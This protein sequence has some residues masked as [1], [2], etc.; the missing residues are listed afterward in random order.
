MTSSA[1]SS[2]RSVGPT[3]PRAA[4]PPAPPSAGATTAGRPAT[5]RPS[6][7]TAP[8]RAAPSS[9]MTG[10]NRL[11]STRSKLPSTS[12]NGRSD[13]STRPPTPLATTAPAVATTADGSLS[14]ASTDPAPR[15]A[16]ATPS[17]P[18]PLPTSRTDEPARDDVLQ[19]LEAQ[20]G[21]LVTARTEGHAGIRDHHDRALRHGLFVGPVSGGTVGTNRRG[22]VVTQ[23]GRTTSRPTD[24]VRSSRGQAAEPALSGVMIRN[25][26]SR[27]PE[28]RAREV[29]H[30]QH[31]VLVATVRTAGRRHGSSIVDDVGFG[32]RRGPQAEQLVGRE[33][34]LVAP[35]PDLDHHAILR[36]Q[37]V[38]PVVDAGRATG[39]VVG[40]SIAVEV[41]SGWTDEGLVT[42]TC[43]KGRA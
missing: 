38:R 35:D 23:L 3:P 12:A 18:V 20:A 39:H 22:R 1:R 2:H 5:S 6:G 34:D 43:R 41:G 25:R 42:G 30:E 31:R 27:P 33:L 14:I 36:A 9:S 15:S 11:A 4:P 21:R 32:H 28:R 26:R 24:H 16:A 29:G 37:S 17:T 19:R 13:T 40:R 10:T 7:A 8:A